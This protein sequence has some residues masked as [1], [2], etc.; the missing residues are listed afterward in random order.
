MT[1]YSERILSGGRLVAWQR[2]AR[3]RAAAK[4][5][6]RLAG[7]VEKLLDIGAADGIGLPF[8]KTAARQVVSVNYYENH[9]QEFRAAHPDD[10]VLTADARALP[11]ADTSFDACTSFETLHLV[12]G[13]AERRKCLAE[14]WRVLRPGGLFVCSLPVEVGYPALIKLAARAATRHQ[15]DGM[16]FSLALRHCCYRWSDLEPFDRGRQIG[17]DVHRFVRDVGNIFVVLQT[18][19]I[20][21]PVLFP[22]NMLV[23]A[24]KRS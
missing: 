21:I 22:M 5:I 13:P 24:R 10:P 15:V 3:F 11:L 4:A 18:K 8:L 7:P 12:P 2:F 17:F 19:A 1:T 14:I 23:V 6:Q 16:G 20:P 9:T